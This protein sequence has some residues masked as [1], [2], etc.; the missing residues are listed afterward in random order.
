M[1][2]SLQHN[3]EDVFMKKTKG[4]A[5]QCIKQSKPADAPIMS[6]LYV[7]FVDIN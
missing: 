2:V 6:A 1:G 7:K 5:K 3:E 4:V